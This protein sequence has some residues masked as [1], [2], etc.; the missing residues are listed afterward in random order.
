MNRRSRSWSSTVLALVSALVLGGLVAGCGGGS[1]DGGGDG[2]P[3]SSAGQITILSED[4]PSTLDLDSPGVALDNS[5]TGVTNLM[6]PL[7]FYA[8]GEVNDEGIQLLDF[9]KIEGRLAESWEYD[10]GAKT[11]TFKLRQGVKSCAGNPFTADDVVYTFARGKSASGGLA[12]A[13]FLANQLGI[14]GFQELGEEGPSRELKDTEVEKVDDFTVRL[15]TVGENPLTLTTL[16][17]FGLS[18]FDEEEMREHATDKD[19]WSHDWTE[20]QGVASFGPYCVESWK[21]HSEFVASANPNYYRG[22]P[23]IQRVVYRAVPSTA[24]RV[25]SVRS[26]AGQL[27][28]HLTPSDYDALR[29]AQDVKVGGVYGNQTLMLQMNWKVEPLDSKELRDAIGFAM[30]YEDIIDRAYFGRARSWKGV[31]PST[32]PGYHEPETQYTHDPE[33]AKQ[34]LAEAGF[35]NGDGLEA[36]KNALQLSY[37]TERSSTLEP[38]ATLVRDALQQVGIPAELNPMPQAQYADARYNKKT[39][40]TVLD[41]AEKPVVPSAAYGIALLFVSNKYG[42]PSNNTNYSNPKVDEMVFELQDTTDD[43]ERD[44]LMAEIQEIVMEDGNYIPIAEYQT[45]W[46]FSPSLRGLTWNTDN[47]IRWYDLSLEE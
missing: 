8:K 14:K 29:G 15:H 40:P 41:D 32:Y 12:H 47:T 4:V 6:E 10:K 23:A 17:H 19:P 38:V 5:Q 46:A 1:D 25:A 24:N 45:Q 9:E 20:N 18:I 35:P 26:G 22:E 43:A 3:A 31:I 34:L 21:K 33:R 2:T 30:P 7:V 37:A 27:A 42:P 44:R 36:N 28:E 39:L 13:W 16:A 11:W